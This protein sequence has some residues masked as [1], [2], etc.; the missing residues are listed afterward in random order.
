VN[1]SL[2]GSQSSNM[3][4]NLSLNPDASGGACVPSARRR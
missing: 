4:S 2:S 3:P 1:V